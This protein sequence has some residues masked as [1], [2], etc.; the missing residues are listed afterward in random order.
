MSGPPKQRTWRRLA[1]VALLVAGC[2][3]PSSPPGT[4]PPDYRTAVCGGLADFAAGNDA[5]FDAF[6]DYM[7]AFMRMTATKSDR[8][9]ALAALARMDARTGKAIDDF[10]AAGNLWEPGADAAEGMA[11]YYRGFK[12]V[13][14]QFKT[15]SESTFIETWKTTLERYT[16]WHDDIAPTYDAAFAELGRFGVD[17]S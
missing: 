4:A 9:D 12:Q 15:S 8:V 3:A 17:C 2:G 5:D 13:L 7:A 11:T 6:I 14:A 1:A 16:A 10:E